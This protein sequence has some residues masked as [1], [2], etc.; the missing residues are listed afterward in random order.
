ML[1][2]YKG[3]EYFVF[4]P[5]GLC[6]EWCVSTAFGV[7]RPH[8]TGQLRQTLKK[9]YKRKVNSLAC[10]ES[11]PITAPRLNWEN[12]IPTETNMYEKNT[13]IDLNVDVNAQ[14]NNLDQDRI[15]YLINRL[16][17]IASITKIEAARPTY[18][19]DDD[20][21][22]STPADLVQ[23][24]KDGKYTFDKKLVNEDGTWKMD[25]YED[26]YNASAMLRWRTVPADKEGFNAFVKKVRA[27]ERKVEDVIRVSAPSD[28]LKAL[29]EF[30]AAEIK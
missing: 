8:P 2:T 20:A 14:S 11:K 28:G 19:M 18:H 25:V 23:R 6:E 27:A 1:I 22:P 10:L 5:R 21:S 15:L 9:I 7:N 30:E 29:Q 3:V 26:W 24:I 17:D 16:S 13:K 12:P 4:K